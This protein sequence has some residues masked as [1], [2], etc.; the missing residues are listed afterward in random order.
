MRK[1]SVNKEEHNHALNDLLIGLVGKYQALILKQEREKMSEKKDIKYIRNQIENAYSS[2]SKIENTIESVLHDNYLKH[3][4]DP[5]VKLDREILAK[6]HNQLKQQSDAIDYMTVRL[7]R[8]TD[9][10]DMHTKNHMDMQ[11]PVDQS[12]RMHNLE[13]KVTLVTDELVKLLK[14][15][16]K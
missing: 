8:V 11:V 12:E 6:I 7:D 14:R 10:I 3:Q 13:L 1:W 15:L 16:D 5:D 4:G 2:L 9:W